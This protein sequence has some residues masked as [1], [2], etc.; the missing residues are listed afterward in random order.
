MKEEQTQKV[1][2]TNL[3]QE[4]RNEPVKMFDPS[5]WSLDDFDL[6]LALGRG[7]YGHVYLAREKKTKFLV[8]I[9]MLYKS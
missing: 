2:M 1:T 6:G 8:A 9:K 4:V 7:K 3:Q 5:D